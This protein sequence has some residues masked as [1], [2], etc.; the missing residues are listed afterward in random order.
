ME[1]ENKK[2]RDV[3]DVAAR[4]M[5]GEKALHPNQQKLDVHEPEKDELTAKDFEMLRNKKKVKEETEETIE[6]GTPAKNTDVADK[7]YLKDMGKKPTVASDLKNLGRFITGKKETNEEVELTE[8]DLGAIAKKHGMELKRTTYG[9]GMKHPTHGE[10]SINR[11]GEWNHKGKT[12][13][14]SNNFSSLDKHLTSLKEEVE[15]LDEV[16]LKTASSAFAKRIGQNEPSSQSKAVQTMQHIAKKHGA[17]GVNTAAKTAEKEALKKIKQEEIDQAAEFVLEYESKDGKFVHR[18]RPGAY[19]GTK[20]EKHAV[21]TLS[22]PKTKEL[23]AIE[24]EKKKKMSEMVATYKEQGLKGLFEALKKDEVIVEEPT[25]AEFDAQLADAKQRAAGTKKQ[26]EVSKPAVQAVQN[27]ETHTTVQFIDYN[28]VNG[29]K[30]SEIDLEERSMTEPEM[31]KKEEIVKSMKKGISGFKERYGKDAKSV[32]YATATKRAMGEE[33]EQIE[34]GTPDG[35]QNRDGRLIP[36]I[37][38]TMTPHE[39]GHDYTTQSIEDAKSK[40]EIHSQHR[41]ALKDNPHPTGSKEHKDWAAGANK[42][43]A[44]H[45]KD[46]S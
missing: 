25:S 21:D 23:K 28:D 15:E 40:S 19:G 12:G 37:H 16:S 38:P 27:E 33:V 46:W 22:G 9:A 36:K 20:D 6:E 14:S 13:N 11:Y 4:I 44:D 32:M 31:K 3:A 24:S 5:M 10:V 43:K 2:L 41:E 1:F 8:D 34:E 7:S 35:Y 45:L 42:A 26:P 17:S 30:I 18:A 29:V 39:H